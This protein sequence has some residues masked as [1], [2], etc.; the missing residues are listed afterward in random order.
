[1]HPFSD[2]NKVIQYLLKVKIFLHLPVDGSCLPSGKEMFELFISVLL[3]THILS[4]VSDL[5]EA[6]DRRMK[7]EVRKGKICYN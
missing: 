7:V 2:I 4:D 1:M 3:L 6:K 5:L